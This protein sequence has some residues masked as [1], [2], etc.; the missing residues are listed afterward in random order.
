[1]T[2][3]S[4]RLTSEIMV[5]F[6]KKS[7]N[8]NICFF[9]SKHITFKSF[10]FLIGKLFFSFCVKFELTWN[11][12][13]VP[14]LLREDWHGSSKKMLIIAMFSQV[15]IMCLASPFLAQKYK[16]LPRSFSI[17]YIRKKYISYLYIPESKIIAILH[18]TSLFN[19]QQKYM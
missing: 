8:F 10:Y 16:M 14:I 2:I 1:M 11:C 12:C 15:T 9:R 19:I 17:V 3:L 4:N 7:W 13:S 6:E 18:I 5:K